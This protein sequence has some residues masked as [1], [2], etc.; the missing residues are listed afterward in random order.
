MRRSKGTNEVACV[1][2]RFAQ[3]SKEER[4]VIHDGL[5]SEAKLDPDEDPSY[6][7]IV[8]T[9]EDLLVELGWE[10]E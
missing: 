3:F 7:A 1:S 2:T 10:P 8:D 6:Q 9:A 4:A 5:M